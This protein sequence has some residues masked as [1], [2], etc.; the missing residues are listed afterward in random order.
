MSKDPSQN[1]YL[2]WQQRGCSAQQCSRTSETVRLVFISDSQHFQASWAHQEQCPQS[3]LNAR[4]SSLPIGTGRN[5]I[6]CII[7]P[8]SNF[9]V[10]KARN[11]PRFALALREALSLFVLGIAPVPGHPLCVS[12]TQS[13][14]RK[15]E[16]QVH[17]KLKAP[18]TGT[19]TLIVIIEF[20]ELFLRPANRLWICLTGNIEA[21]SVWAEKAFGQKANAKDS[22]HEAGGHHRGMASR[23]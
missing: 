2:C 1:S 15:S 6:Q 12:C 9:P 23:V 19:T 7:R 22:Q 17:S 18:D 5:L 3:W 21:L 11:L 20:P 14:G 8:A 13:Q 4:L 10:Q 16:T